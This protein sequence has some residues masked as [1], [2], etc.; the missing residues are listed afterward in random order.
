MKR[1]NIII[2]PSICTKRKS[3]PC[4]TF[5]LN[6][7]VSHFFASEMRVFREMWLKERETSTDF[8]LGWEQASTFGRVYLFFFIISSSTHKHQEKYPQINHSTTEASQKI[9]RFRLFLVVSTPCAAPS[10]SVSR[11]RCENENPWIALRRCFCFGFGETDV[12]LDGVMGCVGEGEMCVCSCC[13][14]REWELSGNFLR[15]MFSSVGGR[16]RLFSQS[17]RD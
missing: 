14:S 10:A 6:K 15:S 4:G 17:K 12:D 5:H 11:L 16:G 8:D 13:I 1:I 7:Q 2:R 9:H 3:K